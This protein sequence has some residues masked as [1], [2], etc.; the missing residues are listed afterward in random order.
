MKLS[1]WEKFWLWRHNVCLKHI[2]AKY[3]NYKY[4]WRCDACLK[5]FSER[6]K[7]KEDKINEKI[8]QLKKKVQQ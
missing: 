2:Q 7:Q 3:L 5:E 4:K 6:R 1:I 8:L